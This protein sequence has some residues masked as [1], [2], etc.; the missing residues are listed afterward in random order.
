[1]KRDITHGEWH[2]VMTEEEHAALLMYGTLTPEEGDRPA[3]VQEGSYFGP[4][5]YLLLEYSK[6]C[7]RGCCYDDVRELVPGE[8]AVRELQKEIDRVSGVLRRGT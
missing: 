6:R 3:T 7:P 5:K 1:M 8:Q 2:A 4:G